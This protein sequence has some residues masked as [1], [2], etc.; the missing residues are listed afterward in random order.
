[1]DAVEGQD[2]KCQCAWFYVY[3]ILSVETWQQL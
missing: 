2:V 3:L 1:M